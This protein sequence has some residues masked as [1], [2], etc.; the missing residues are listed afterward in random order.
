MLSQVYVVV[1]NMYEI[2]FIRFIWILENHDTYAQWIN[3]VECS[4]HLS[5]FDGRLYS[6]KTQQSIVKIYYIRWKKQKNNIKTTPIKQFFSTIKKRKI[7]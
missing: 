3:C 7:A 5:H 2:Y 4:K 6:A 1:I